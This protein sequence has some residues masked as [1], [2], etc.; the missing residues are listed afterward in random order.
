[1]GK[2][3]G[4]GGARAER[5]SDCLVCEYCGR[6]WVNKSKLLRHIKQVHSGGERGVTC[7]MVARLKEKS[8]RLQKPGDK[9]RPGA[10]EGPLHDGI[11]NRLP[12]DG[13]GLGSVKKRRC[14]ARS[15]SPY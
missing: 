15:D 2:T 4:R 1:M 8:A 7:A 12:P 5:P 6:E 13:A 3:G 14:V 11:F 10:A 9:I